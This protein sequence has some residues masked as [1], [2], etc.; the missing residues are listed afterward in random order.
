MTGKATLTE[1][2]KTL[3]YLESQRAG[4]SN[5]FIDRFLSWNRVKGFMG[6]F[7]CDRLPSLTKRSSPFALISNLSKESELGSHFIAIYADQDNLYY[8]DSYGR[9]LKNDDIIQSVKRANRTLTVVNQNQIQSSRSYFCAWYCIGFI[10]CVLKM[11][12]NPQEFLTPF[13]NHPTVQNDEILKEWIC[14]MLK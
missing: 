12:W 10:L 5:L 1:R 2:I 13:N 7:S 6:T 3:K 4:L 14:L 9:D 8:F 11:E